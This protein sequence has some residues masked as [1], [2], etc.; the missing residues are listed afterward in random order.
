M[1]AFVTVR[2]VKLET[3]NE[4]RKDLAE[5]L[6]NLKKRKF[7]KIK[8]IGIRPDELANATVDWFTNISQA[9]EKNI[10]DWLESIYLFCSRIIVYRP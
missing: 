6:G 9:K 4:I 3:S 7:E 10:D 5:C 2:D 1:V 8:L